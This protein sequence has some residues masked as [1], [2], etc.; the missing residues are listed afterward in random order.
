MKSINTIKESKFMKN[1]ISKFLFLSLFVGLIFTASSADAAK[2]LLPIIKDGFDTYVNGSV[3]GQDGWTNY[4]NGDNFIV[5]NTTAYKSKKALHNNSLGDSVVTKSGASLSDGEQTVY[6]RTENRSNWG[7]YQDGNA[8]VRLSQGQSFQS[9]IFTAV[10]FKS[11]GNVAYYDP[12]SDSYKNFDTYNDNQWTKL[13]IEW[14][15]SD[16]TA[17]YQVNNGTWTNWQTFKNS[18]SFTTFDNVG[19]DFDLPGGSGG[20][21]FDALQ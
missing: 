15:S 12:I 16:K 9:S 5:Q 18:A 1:L 14:R 2:K 17:R 4:T 10:S 19:F 8:Q 3:V 21:Y 7:L 6:I 11:D 13:T 20:V